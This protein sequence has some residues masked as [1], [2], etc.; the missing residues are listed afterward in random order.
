MRTLMRV[1]PRISVRAFSLRERLRGEPSLKLL[2][3]EVSRGD[4]VVD[5][6]AHRGVYTDR[7]LALVGPQGH[8]HAFEPNPASLPILRA[9]AA[10]RKNITI[11]PAALSSESG[12][13]QLHRPIADGR[14]V[15]AMS[16]VALDGM[17][18]T[19]EHDT[20]SVRLET[21]D[22][23][24]RS[25]PRRIAFIKCDVEGHEHAVLL[26]AIERLG[27]DHP[28]LLL[29][30]EQRHRSQDVRETFELLRGLGYDGW[31]LRR[32]GPL[33]VDEFDVERDQLR[34]LTG[35]FHRG[36][37][38]PDYLTDFVFRM[39]PASAGAAGR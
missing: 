8:V 22:G 27:R 15:D 9:V 30:I 24:L 3:R 36:R 10:G 28:T 31:V 12:G 17:R 26:G 6:G 14:R 21:L 37:P 16:S 20:V 23:A 19:V 2:E 1:A 38:H 32:T 25:E 11:Y 35:G 18:E 29:E 7:L 34:Y 13:G 5:I 39:P 33:P 4:V